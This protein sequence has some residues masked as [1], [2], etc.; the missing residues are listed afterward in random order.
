MAGITRDGGFAE[1]CL[2]DSRTSAK[3]PDE[4]SFEQAA[5]L[6]CAGVTIYAAIKKAVNCGLKDGGVSRLAS[7]VVLG[8]TKLISCFSN[9][10]IRLSAL[11][12]WGKSLLFLIY[13]L[14]CS[15]PQV[16]EPWVILEC[17]LLNAW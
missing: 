5:P 4:M 16:L 8:A 10:F 6:M 7:N 1:Y 15:H 13:L 12:V 9:L 3:L 14:T 11:W 17:N 2:L